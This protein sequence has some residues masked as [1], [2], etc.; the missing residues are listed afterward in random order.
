MTYD[1]ISIFD[2]NGLFYFADGGTLLGCVR[3]KGIIPWDDDV[4]LCIME[5]DTEKFLSYVKNLKNAV[6]ELLKHTMLLVLHL[7][8][9]YFIYH[10]NI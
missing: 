6:M 1:T 9:K 2:N 7:D 8:I 10:V 5:S 4:D 3:H